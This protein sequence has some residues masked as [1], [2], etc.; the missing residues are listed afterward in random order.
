MYNVQSLRKNNELLELL[1]KW[2]CLS[3]NTLKELLNNNEKGNTFRQRIYRLEKEGIIK[4]RIFGSISKIV[5]PSNDLI[6]YLGNDNKSLI[7]EEN[8]R[9]DAIV[10]LVTSSFLKLGIANEASLP[11]EYQTK[12][13]R[14]HH[15]IEPDAILK[16]THGAETYN[17]ALEVELWR[18][19]RKRIYEKLAEYAKAFEYDY[20]FY[21]FGDEF[22]F[23]SYVKRLGEITND[24]SYSHLKEELNEKIILFLESDLSK[25]MV[26]LFESKIFHNKELKK[27]SELLGD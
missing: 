9:H 20:V 11:H 7:N 22:S 2:R 26:N 1:M 14:R 8:I 17:V 3:L 16:I 23:N 4:S 25:S 15:A 19:D 5:F 12:S 18:K 10:A 6:Q 13:T 24:S 27:L 21:F